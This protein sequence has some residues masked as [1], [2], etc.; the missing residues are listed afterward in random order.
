MNRDCK[1]HLAEFRP[2]ELRSRVAENSLVLVPIGTI[3]WHGGHLPLGT[4]AL[5]SQAV[6]DELA[7]R[8]GCVVAPPVWYGVCRDLAPQEGYYGTINTISEET[9][10]HLLVDILLGLSQLEFK[11]A[12]LLS[13]H[14]ETE[15]FGAIERAMQRSP[16]T[17]HF[18]T[19]GDFVQD[20]VQPMEDVQQTWPFAGDH[21]G[22]FETSMVQH[23]YPHLVEMDDAPEAIELDMPG[24]PE[25]IRRRYPR[26]ASPAYGQ[27]LRDQI[28]SRGEARLREILHLGDGGFCHRCH[29]GSQP[30][31]GQVDRASR[32][33][34]TQ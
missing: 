11:V 26:R 5:L 3:E 10:E 1:I 19:A 29:A 31:A 28:V 13:G 24:L 17:V 22:E 7:Q 30:P 9:L 8:L 25:Y 12:V 6:C 27:H 16:I 32:G 33:P 20:V 21:A 14:F 23:Y 34:S 15:H 2:E 18:L 4:D